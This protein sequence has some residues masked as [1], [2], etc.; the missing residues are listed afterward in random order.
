VR[1]PPHPRHHLQ[2]SPSLPKICANRGSLGW[3]LLSQSICPNSVNAKQSEIPSRLVSH[4]GRGCH[5]HCLA[6]DM[7][8]ITQFA[9]RSVIRRLESPDAQTWYTNI[10][11]HQPAF[12]DVCPATPSDT[13]LIVTGG[14]IGG[15]QPQQ[16]ECS[17][18]ATSSHRATTRAP[19]IP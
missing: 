9:S 3:D 17:A 1:Q 5:L 8:L 2:I 13:E 18:K 15:L 6:N 16:L 19:S 4:S 10:L 14:T 12:S 7:R 11:A